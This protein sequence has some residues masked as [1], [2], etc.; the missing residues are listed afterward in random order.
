MA[1]CFL[2]R[3]TQLPAQGDVIPYLEK[4]VPTAPDTKIRNPAAK[5]QKFVA[6]GT[7]CGLQGTISTYTNHFSWKKWPKFV[8][9]DF[10]GEKSNPQVFMI[11]LV[12]SQEYIKESAFCSTF[13]C[14]MWP[15]LAKSFSG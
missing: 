12:G 10:T 11:I 9:S 4:L 13:I 1:R 5:I 6:T 3:C 14:S 15:N 8:R 7:F 2:L